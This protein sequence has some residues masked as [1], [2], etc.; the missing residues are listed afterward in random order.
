MNRF[1]ITLFLFIPLFYQCT[2]SP[3]SNA[4]GE[5]TSS[6]VPENGMSV[7]SATTSHADTVMITDMKFI[8]ASLHVKKGDTVIWIN[9]DLVSHCITE[10]LAKSW[11]SGPVPAGTSWKM[12][13]TSGAEYYCAIHQVMKGSL[14]LND[15]TTA[16]LR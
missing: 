16:D 10:E 7:S 9:N 3:E 15:R 5:D 1:C 11:T 6:Y 8:P 12:V 2:S 14:V 13:I 4:S